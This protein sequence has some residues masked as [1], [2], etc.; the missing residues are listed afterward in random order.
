MIR[1]I[2]VSVFAFG[3]ALALCS[4]PALA[5]QGPDFSKIEI[6]ATKVAGGVYML[7]G[8][9]GNIAASVGEDGI[10]IVDDQFAP[11]ADKIRAAL[12][13]LGITDKPVRFVI[14]THY[15]GDHTGGNEPFGKT[16]TII[17]HENVRKRLAVGGPAG[18]GGSVSFDNEPK[19]KDTLPVITFSKDVTIHFNGEDIRVLHYPSGHTDG[20][21]V[22]FFPKSNVVHMGDDFVRY[23]FPFVDVVAGGSVRGMI[24]ACENAL[25]D[26]PADVKVIP[27][28]GE[29]SNVDDVRAFI[30]ML[31]ETSAV[32]EKAIKAGKTVE[33]MKEEKIL[34]PWQ[35]WSGNFITTDAFIETLHASMTGGLGKGFQT[36]N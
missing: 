21:A 34:E 19:G 5:Q 9:G 24:E 2:I 17:A 14:N 28:H 10:V 32:A 25:A 16:S 33:Q 18:N 36:H 26:L 27:G 23:G 31:E 8:T 12:V 7:V 22:V 35:K 29:I 30:K 6:K 15:H 3:A 11:L 4:P 20:D 13:K 1:K